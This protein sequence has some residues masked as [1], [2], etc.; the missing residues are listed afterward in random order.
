MPPGARKLVR[1]ARPLRQAM[2]T[3]ALL[4]ACRFLADQ[5]QQYS[6]V[7]C[8]L[9]RR[10][11]L[12]GRPPPRPHLPAWLLQPAARWAQGHAGGGRIC[13]AARLPLV[14]AHHLRLVVTAALDLLVRTMGTR[15]RAG[16]GRICSFF[17]LV[18]LWLRQVHATSWVVVI[19]VTP[20]LD[21]LLRW[22]PE[23]AGGEIVLCL[24]LGCRPSKV[25]CA[26]ELQCLR[27]Y[28]CRLLV[29]LPA[30]CTPARP[31]NWP[32]IR[33]LAGGAAAAPRYGGSL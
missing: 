33:C 18:L 24:Q 20:A 4:F 28:R 8:V 19:T 31:P 3:R 9:C 29:Q 6:M 17:I 2:L 22:S 12:R 26:A 32:V 5:S 25:A 13:C 23:H 15:T 21:V 10:Q 27:G 1:A 30:R 14:H 16:G 7:W 11:H